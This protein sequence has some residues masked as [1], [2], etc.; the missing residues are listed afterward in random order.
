MSKMTQE[1]FKE[2]FGDLML[3]GLDSIQTYIPLRTNA[4]YGINVAIRP[5]VMRASTGVVLFG[6]KLRVG[7]TLDDK[8]DPVKTTV[9]DIS[10]AVKEQRL[11]DFCKGFSWQ[12]QNAGRFSTIIGVGLAAS[13]FDGEVALSVLEENQVASD[14]INRLERTY[15]Q[16]NGVTFGNNK[17]AAIAALNAAWVLQS[18]NP[19]IFKPLPE[20][21]QL[22]AEVVGKQTPI[23]NKAQDKYRDNVVS[24]QQKVDD[25]AEQ[26]QETE[27]DSV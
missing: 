25:W 7:Y 12:K 17:A 3:N 20:T 23:L 15:K 21:K 27:E 13:T 14:F 10:D 19:R 4:R 18:K 6:G 5:M 2:M 22:P 16:Y 1:V 11:I 26:A 24:F 8:H 9:T